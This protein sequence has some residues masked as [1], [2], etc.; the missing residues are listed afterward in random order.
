MK[1]PNW[2]ANGKGL[3]AGLLGLVL[4]AAGAGPAAAQSDL[5]DPEKAF[6][7]TAE[8]VGPDRVRITWD[9]AEDYYLYRDKL[10]LEVVEPGGVSVA[11]IEKP[12][13]KEKYDKTFD[14]RLQ[15][16]RGEAHLTADLEGLNGAREV[17][18]TAHYQG[19]ADAGVCY[20]PQTADFDLVL[21]TAAA[22]APDAG[23]GGAAG[24]SGDA[25]GGEG[26]SAGPQGPASEQTRFASALEAGGWTVVGVFFL[27][28]LALAFTPCIFPMI[29][30]LSGIIVGQ[31]GEGR[32]MTKTRAFVLSLAYVLGVAV[33]YAAL[34]V[35]AGA[36]GAAIQAALQDPWVI[37]AFAA[38]FVALAL[39][40]FGF[41]DLQLPASLQTRLQESQ[42]HLGR[43]SV[44][45]TLVM[46]VLSALIVGPCVAPPLAGALIYIGQ[47]GD[48]ALGGLSLFVMSLGMGVPLLVVGTTAGSVMPRAGVWMNIVKYVFGVLLL[49]VAIYLLSRI[50]PYPVSLLL[51]GM[52]LVVSGIYMGAF[53][54]HDPEVSGWRRLWKGLGLVLVILGALELVG[55]VTGAQDPLRPLAKVTATSGGAGGG[56][57]KSHLEFQ[58]VANLEELKAVIDEA[59]AA[60]RPLM[61]DFYADWCVECVRYERTTFRS[62]EVAQILDRHDVRLVQV[63]VTEQNQAH[64]ALQRHFNIVGPPAIM[65]YNRDGEEMSASRVAGYMDAEAFLEHVGKVY[66]D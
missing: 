14:E 37:G 43:G 8:A 56:S 4:I 28:G 64:K 33:T 61:L 21:P 62:P 18:V 50:L 20:P 25:A 66:A 36:T 7:P 2:V 42:Q 41:Y 65:F 3:L 9:V 13:G 16:F 47:T 5:L 22:A 35:I 12:P 55:G 30:I 24:G 29:P 45:G 57:E 11:G 17:T 34:G 60:D 31:G 63:D 59:A 26:A 51:W 49:G 1:N 32:G 23:D 58:R 54:R 44:V 46:G 38:V 39:S 15:V 19:C 10:D 40:M 53:D 48:M 6:K 27:A 52:L